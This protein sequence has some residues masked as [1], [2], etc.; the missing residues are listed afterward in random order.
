MGLHRCG[1]FTKPAKTGF[2]GCEKSPFR[3]KSTSASK[4]FPKWIREK[5]SK[6]CVEF[7]ELNVKYIGNPNSNYKTFE[8][9][10]ILYICVISLLYVRFSP[11]VKIEIFSPVFKTGL[12]ISLSGVPGTPDSIN[13]F[14]TRFQNGFEN[15]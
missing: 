12:K 13:E 7:Q 15:D 1:Q 4:E 11:E 3:K 2:V 14:Q 8:V 9:L 10:A 6:I 5:Y